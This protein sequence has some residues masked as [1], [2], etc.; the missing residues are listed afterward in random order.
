MYLRPYRTGDLAGMYLLDTVCF[1]APFRF[2]RD[3]MR[4][5]AEA[6]NA[7]VRLACEVDETNTE[8]LAG[9]CIAHL[10]QAERKMIGYVVTLDVDPAFRRRGVGPTL[11]RSVELAARDAGARWMLLH[12]WS[13][14]EAAIRLYERMGYS[15]LRNEEGFYEPGI[16]ALVYRKPLL[17]DLQEPATSTGETK[18]GGGGRDE[19]LKAS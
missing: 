13:G 2:S 8:R 1:E 18:P 9:F 15:Y 5:F 17:P 11:M 6:E 4:R 14:N 12:V 16:D 7:L 3:A 19:P 10:E